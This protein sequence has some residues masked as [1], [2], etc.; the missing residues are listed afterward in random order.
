MPF[1]AV[2]EAEVYVMRIG[3]DVAESS[4]LAAGEPENDHFRVDR[5]EHLLGFR[6]FHQN[7]LTQRERQVHDAW[8]TARQEIEELW[9]RLSHKFHV[10]KVI[11]SPCKTIPAPVTEA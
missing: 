9:A 7:Q 3:R 8:G 11:G 1:R 4:S 2:M 6:R 5:I 10:S